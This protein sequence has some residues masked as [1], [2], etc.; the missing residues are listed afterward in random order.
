MNHQPFAGQTLQTRDLPGYSLAETVYPAAWKMPRHEHEAAYFS[1]VL[2][3]GYD[4][5]YGAKT[6]SCQPA[7][8]VF[9][10]PG[11]NH[12]VVFH[13]ERVRI[14]RV[15][16]KPSL[17]TR[18]RECTTL[19]DSPAA[20]DG[21][22]PAQLAT[23]LYHETQAR[24]AVAPLAIEALVLEV[25]T[26]AARQ[27]ETT[28][29][30]RLPHWLARSRELLHEH[31]HN[32]LTLSE[33]ATRVG[34]HP[35]YLA[36]VFRQ[37]FH[38][39]VGEYVRRLRIERACQQMAETDAALVDIA[40]AVGFYDQSHFTRTFKRMTGMTPAEFRAARKRS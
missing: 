2:Q 10:P 30:T 22:P 3:G 4:E 17:L 25:L 19:L 21:G 5:S 15:Q 24:D 26:A 32:E 34:V 9:H 35:V 23:R 29:D 11:E 1:L 13:Q 38:C 39:S 28:T 40:H 31:C 36:R 20:F 27:Q 18:I 12:A 7:S 37:H 6:R 16:V 33:V 14:F 8:L